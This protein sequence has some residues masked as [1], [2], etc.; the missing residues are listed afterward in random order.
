VDSGSASLAGSVD[1]ILIEEIVDL[2]TERDAYRMLAQQALHA[3]HLV[4]L[5]RDVLRAQRAIDQR[6]ATKER[7][8][9]VA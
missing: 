8:R 9:S 4:T 7:T 6:R 3:L 1:S 5:E 2:T